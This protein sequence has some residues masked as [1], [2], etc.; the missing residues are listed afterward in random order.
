MVVIWDLDDVLHCDGVPTA[1]AFHLQKVCGAH[2][3]VY[4]V[5]AS[6]RPSPAS[7][8]ECLDSLFPREFMEQK[9]CV[10]S[11]NRSFKQIKIEHDAEPKKNFYGYAIGYVSSLFHSATRIENPLDQDPLPY[12]NQKLFA[13]FACLCDAD[14]K[15]PV[16]D[17][18]VLVDD[19]PHFHDIFKKNVQCDG[20]LMELS[21]RRGI[22]LM[23]DRPRWISTPL[24]HC[25]RQGLLP[26]SAIDQM[27]S[28][29]KKEEQQKEELC[30]LGA[31]VGASGGV[32]LSAVDE[33]AA[34]QAS[35][36]HDDGLIVASSPTQ[37]TAEEVAPAG[38]PAP[39]PGAPL[40]KG[41]FLEDC[42]LGAIFDGDA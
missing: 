8:I 17:T 13:P 7:V 24:A 22:A 28:A 14:G 18:V 31:L 26:S 27:R 20:P 21:Y 16:F 30:V 29:Q 3:N 36:I 12:F 2:D 19:N 32:S 1:F 15:P 35:K 33:S 34:A 25:V 39:L 11:D 38:T 4:H 23:I 6:S 41:V 5:I 37:K 40:H 9:L 10:P 42:P